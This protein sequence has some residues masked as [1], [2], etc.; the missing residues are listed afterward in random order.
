MLVMF[1]RHPVEDHGDW[2]TVFAAFFQTRKKAGVTGEAVY[3]S[4][5]DPNEVTLAL[6]FASLEEARAFP[7]NEKLKGAY[8]EAHSVGP[9]AVL[10]RRPGLTIARRRSS[11]PLLEAKT[12]RGR[13]C[14]APSVYQRD[15]GCSRGLSRGPQ[16][17]LQ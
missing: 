12:R 14:K 2:R 4:V 1:V 8:Q 9:P 11:W 15:S 6:E 10:V 17:R 3:R 5:D 7:D 13:R 16:C